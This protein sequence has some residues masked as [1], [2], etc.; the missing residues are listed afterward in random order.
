MAI[1]RKDLRLAAILMMNHKAQ[2]K[3][4]NSLQLFKIKLKQHYKKKTKAS[5]ILSLTQLNSQ[6]DHP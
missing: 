3:Y 2:N 5:L 4:L 1:L 6:F